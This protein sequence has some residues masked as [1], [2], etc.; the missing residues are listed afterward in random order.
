MCDVGCDNENK[1]LI[2]AT[3]GGGVFTIAEDGTFTG[4]ATIDFNDN[5]IRVTNSNDETI[6]ALA[7]NNE[8]LYVA[9]EDSHSDNTLIR[10]VN[11]T[12]S[13]AASVFVEDLPQYLQS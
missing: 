4:I 5:V 12:L 6:V 7:S 11:M 10:K 1:L 13:N 9:T 3:T 8:I 2:G